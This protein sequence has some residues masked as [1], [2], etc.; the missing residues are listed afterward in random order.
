MKP[1][2]GARS[3]FDAHQAAGSTSSDDAHHA[4]TPLTDTTVAV[5]SYNIGYQNNEFGANNWHRKFQK[6]QNDV[7]SVFSH[8][9]G[10]QIMLLSEFGNMFASAD[11]I[12]S[13]GVT[14]PTGNTLTTVYN[15]REVFENLLAD[16]DMT[17]IH[18]YAAAP[19][20]ALIDSHCWRVREHEVINKL[21]SKQ[22][23][24]IQHLILE[25]VDTSG[26]LRCFNAHMPTSAATPKRKEDCV[27][28][29]CYM[30]TGTGVQQP[31]AIMPWIIAG[32]LNVDIGT[33]SKFCQPFVK[34]GA[35][36]FSKSEW[37]QDNDAQKA[38]HAL[39]QGIALLPIRSWVGWHSKPCA[40]DA[41]D[42]VVVMGAFL[43]KESQPLF[44][45]SPLPH[46]VWAKSNTTTVAE[47]TR[48][49]HVQD[50]IRVWETTPDHAERDAPGTSSVPQPAATKDQL[51][52]QVTFAQD[53][54]FPEAHPPDTSPVLPGLSQDVIE[55]TSAPS[56][57]SVLQPAATQEHDT[58]AAESDPGCDR[59]HPDHV[60][61]RHCSYTDFRLNAEK[62]EVSEENELRAVMPTSDTSGVA[63]PAHADILNVIEGISQTAMADNAEE[64]PRLRLAAQDLLQVLY[65]IQG[66]Y[67]IRPDDELV[68]KV[69]FPIRVRKNMVQRIANYRGAPQPAGTRGGFTVQQWIAWY[70]SEP[71]SDPDFE[72]ALGKWKEEFP[73]REHTRQKIEGWLEQN[74]RESK[75]K[76]RDLHH[77]A[78]QAY[79]QQ[80][81]M[82][83]Q[84]ALAL[85]KHPKA[86]LNSLLEAW[87]Q[88]LESPQYLQE[89]ERS[90]KQDESNQEA[91]EVKRR[92]VELKMKVHRLRHQVRQAK[93]MHR[94]PHKITREN[95]GL[96]QRWRSG[97]LGDE[98][99]EYTRVHG[100]GKLE[101]TGEVLRRDGYPRRHQ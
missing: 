17:H 52:K 28:K 97:Q 49:V 61:V 95:R 3:S 77:G 46:S 69:S 82:N 47:E 53:V 27:T 36:C 24:I 80:E 40:S 51:R 99:E 14:Q 62:G 54:I 93:V 73:M 68:L 43:E 2:S 84:L 37:P 55:G 31:S 26:T 38:D 20:V 85:L 10:I 63:Q 78:F 48:H 29:M 100:Y 96:Y 6:L 67:A 45:K 32:D 9:T 44:T 94:N 8:E 64:P 79:L 42:A 81:C 30:A 39:S 18:V 15:T 33:M 13:S 72:W 60:E 92:Q 50:V 88:Y 91:M 23:I 70:D 66:G 87:A 12:F 11:K 90:R 59:G 41:H 58:S 19:Y 35:P 98:L 56:T 22:E 16:V 34:A 5:V 65:M 76:A 86:M 89:R 7:A 1:S 25:H 71:L 101:S 75:K 57:S 83:K 4:A 74:T 21:C